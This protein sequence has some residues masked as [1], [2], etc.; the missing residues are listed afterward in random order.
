[1]WTEVEPSQEEKQITTAVNI[2]EKAL[3]GW[4]RRALSSA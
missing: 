2:P 4:D 1:M 3:D